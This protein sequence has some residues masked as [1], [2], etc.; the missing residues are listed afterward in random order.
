MAQAEFAEVTEAEVQRNRRNGVNAD[1]NEQVLNGERNGTGRFQDHADHIEDDQHGKRAEQ[2][3]GRFGNGRLFQQRFGGGVV[4]LKHGSPSL[5]F[6]LDLLAEDARRP[7]QEHENQDAED[8]G[9][10]QFG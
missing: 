7:D 4:F 9:V 5:H 2:G 10:G 1:V 8:N 3:F 6:L